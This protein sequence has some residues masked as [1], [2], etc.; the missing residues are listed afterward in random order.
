MGKDV[1]FLCQDMGD[2]PFDVR[3]YRVLLYQNTVAG[4]RRLEEMLREAFRQY[5]TN[6]HA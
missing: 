5:T 2:V 4:M 3:H 1:I 6:K